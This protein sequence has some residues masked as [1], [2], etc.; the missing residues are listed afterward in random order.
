MTKLFCANVT[1]SNKKKNNK[2]FFTMNKDEKW[3]DYF[4]NIFQLILKNIDM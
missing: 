3:K 1:S 2:I 4:Y